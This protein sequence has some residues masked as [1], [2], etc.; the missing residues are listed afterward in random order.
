MDAKKHPA[1]PDP[2]LER[3]PE[4]FSEPRTIPHGWDLSEFLQP[5]NWLPGEPEAIPVVNSPLTASKSL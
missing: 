5:G 2:L 3:S 4:P 1:K